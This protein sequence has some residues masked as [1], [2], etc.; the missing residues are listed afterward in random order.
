MEEAMGRL[1]LAA[2]GEAGWVKRCA[3]KGAL[4]KSAS[5]ELLD[6]CLKHLGGKSTANGMVVRT[7]FNPTTSAVEFRLKTP[8]LGY[9]GSRSQLNHPS[10]EHV[11]RDLKFLYSSLIFPETMEHYRPQATRESVRD[12]AAKL[13]D[14]KQFMK[15]YTFDEETVKSPRNIHLWCHVELTDHSKDELLLPRELIV[16]PLNATV[17]DL[18]FEV[19]KT[20]Q[21]VY[22]MFKRFQA[23]GFPEYGH[24]EDSLSV[25]LLTGLNGSVRV[26]GKCL[27]M[28]GLNRFRMERGIENWTV[29]CVCGAKDDDGERMLACDTCGVWQHTRC[30][31]IDNSDSVPSK[32]VC[33]SCLDSSTQVRKA[34]GFGGNTT[35]MDFSIPGA[36]CRV[37]AMLTDDRK[38]GSNV[39]MSYGVP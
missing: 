19:T 34:S 25:K 2:V 35:N 9:D 37:Q 5:P 33:K 4:Y 39:N 14:C 22:A 32:Y 8:I 15:D 36:T 24:I 23:V 17:A 21:D 6:Y 20:F 29:D 30:A 31:G 26:Q 18:K 7:R 27:S 10:R 1:L 16:L 12:S 13:L 28:H 3:L 38:V 11:I